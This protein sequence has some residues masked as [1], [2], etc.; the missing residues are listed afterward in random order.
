M[1]M[2]LYMWIQCLW[3]PEEGARTPEAGITGGS[4]PPAVGARDWIWVPTR[5]APALN[6]W[7]ISLASC[8]LLKVNSMKIITNVNIIITSIIKKKFKCK[9]TF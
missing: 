5:A 9:G 3:G 8:K 7:T 4:Q 1:H 2:Y 6:Y